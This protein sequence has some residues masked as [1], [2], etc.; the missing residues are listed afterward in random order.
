MARTTNQGIG[1]DRPISDG[2]LAEST[3]AEQACGDVAVEAIGQALREDRERTLA[4][5]AT[6]KSQFD[7]VVAYSEGSPPDDEHD[8]E[9]AT[10]AF[11][12]AQ[13]S[14]LLDQARTH[15]AETE[16][17]LARLANGTYGTCETCGNPIPA[18]RLTIRPQARTCTTCT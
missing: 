7:G 3:A 11:E 16:A 2:S 12:R 5:I 8:P 14:A 6:F 17:A 10:I 9:G 1:D 4:R 18:E 15:L 13:L